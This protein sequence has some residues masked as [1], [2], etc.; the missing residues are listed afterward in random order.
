[1]PRIVLTNHLSAAAGANAFDL[2]GA[3]VRETL[4]SLFAQ[5]PN[6]RGY[7]LDDQGA[8][9]HHVAAFV[10]GAVVLDK[11]SLA[12]PVPPDGEVFIAQALSGG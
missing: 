3:T 10:N 6:L 9:R 2:P 12:T 7:L 8:L 4:E 5:R 11:A 1:M